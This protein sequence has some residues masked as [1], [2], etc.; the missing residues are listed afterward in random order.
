MGR[1]RRDYTGHKFNHFTVLDCTMKQGNKG[2]YI[3]RAECD[4][5]NTV[6]VSTQTIRAEDKNSCGC[7]RAKN[8]IGEKQNNFTVI[9]KV[10]NSKN[11]QSRWL[12]EC[13][14]GNQFIIRDDTLKKKSQ[15]GC[16]CEHPNKIG[17]LNPA[18]KGGTT[19]NTRKGVAHAKWVKEVLERDG[20]T[21]QR[22]GAYGGNNKLNAHHLNSYSKHKDIRWN[23]DNGATL[24]M[25]CH[26][27]FHKTYGYFDFTPEDYYKYTKK[28][29]VA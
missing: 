2:N 6:E 15:I 29:K 25:G 20:F 7:L 9:A 26:V 1:P 21:C 19:V 12:A 17:E 8:W 3:W 5:G 4:C 10:D 18:W 14:C 24:C 28:E 11:R 23:V 27:E 22:C 16:G 13:K